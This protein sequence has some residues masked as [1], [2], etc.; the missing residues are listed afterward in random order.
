MKKKEE[1]REGGKNG[2]KIFDLYI[3]KK[4]ERE[5]E[6]EKEEEKVFSVFFSFSSLFK[7]LK[8]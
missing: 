7:H 6:G 3:D 4:K 8:K 1:S 2:S 5:R